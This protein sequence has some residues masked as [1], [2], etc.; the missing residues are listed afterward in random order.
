VTETDLDAYTAPRT[1][2]SLR[3]Y[4]ADV[5]FSDRQLLR[6]IRARKLYPSQMARGDE[7][8][9]LDEMRD[10]IEVEVWR[11]FFALPRTPDDPGR[12]ARI[13]ITYH[14]RDRQVVFEVAHDLGQVISDEQA[15]LGIAEAQD[16]LMGAEDRVRQARAL[17]QEK[18]H[19]LVVKRVAVANARNPQESAALA[20]EQNSLRRLTL[21]A[22]EQVRT[23]EKA[24]Q[25]MWMRLQ[26]ETKRL[27]L[28]FE[29]IDGGR[30]ATPGPSKKLVLSLLA[31]LGFCSMLP[32]VMMGVGGVDDRVY[33]VEDVRRLGLV[34]LGALPRFCGDDRGALEERLRAERHRRE[35]DGA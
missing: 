9:A 13:A 3:D 29:L 12:S 24:R 8:M 5:C 2:G 21:S 31:V 1:I 17:A 22:D 14:G 19:E 18:Q 30:V 34:A 33:E 28:Q 23:A 20:I 7:R 6:V 16:A 11:N 26:L 4:V 15:S 35:G 10:D 25:A 32:L 27:G